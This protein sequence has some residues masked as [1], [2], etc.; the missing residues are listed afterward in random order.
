MMNLVDDVSKIIQL[1]AIKSN[2][3]ATVFEDNEG[4]LKVVKAPTLTA[5]MKHIALEMHH[6]RSH[7]RSGQV[8]IE[9]IDTKEQITDTD[10]L[11]KPVSEEQFIYLRCKM[12]GE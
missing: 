3:R 12:M 7:V 1:L 2:L 6:F 10:I 5:R 11:T 4:A 8:I 9:S